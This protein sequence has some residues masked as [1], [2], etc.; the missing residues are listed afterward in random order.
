MLKKHGRKMKD[1]ITGQELRDRRALPLKTKEE[2]SKERIID[3]HNNFS[4]NICVSFSGG[5][6]ST[7]LLHLVREIFPDVVGVF[8]DTGLEYP[9]IRSFAKSVDNVI[10]LKPKVSFQKI[11][12]RYG[13]PVVSREVAGFLKDLQKPTPRNKA[14]RHLRMT[15]YN[16]KGEYKPLERLP[17]KWYKLIDAPFRI[18]DHCCHIMKT[19]PLN[20]YHKETGQYPIIG[21]RA[22]ESRFRER[23]Y[24]RTGCNAYDAVYP[25]STPLAVWTEQNILEYLSKNN[26]EYASVY[27]KLKKVDGLYKLTGQQRTGC[28][29]C[30]FGV[31]MEKDGENRFQ[32]MKESHPAQYR[33][34]IDK[35][36]CGKVLDFIGVKY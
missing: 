24:L 22:E 23:R 4:G 21:L 17:K 3:W 25:M 1:K 14:L 35:L 27:G 10:L 26:L 5:K 13:Y 12:S 7:V 15:G 18:S 32:K 31:H 33:M 6:D 8:V 19:E 28:M 29:F 36:G 16:K 2:L 20:R 9:E 11:I 30:M 34:C